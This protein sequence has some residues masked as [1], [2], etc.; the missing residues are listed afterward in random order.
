MLT[1]DGFSIPFGDFPI[2]ESALGPQDG[3][4]TNKYLIPLPPLMTFFQMTTK[5]KQTTMAR[6]T[7]SINHPKA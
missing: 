7:N 6:G 3:F 4:G 5:L 2:G 1:K